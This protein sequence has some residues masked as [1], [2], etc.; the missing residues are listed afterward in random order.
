MRK[1][2]CCST[3]F[4]LLCV[5]GVW[6]FGQLRWKSLCVALFWYLAYADAKYVLK[7]GGHRAKFG[8]TGVEIYANE[9]ICSYHVLICNRCSAKSIT[10]T[11]C[12]CNVFDITGNIIIKKKKKKTSHW[13]KNFVTWYIEEIRHL[14]ELRSKYQ[15]QNYRKTNY[16]F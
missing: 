2:Q 10:V 3:Q 5:K 7:N 11:S 14:L 1:T 13:R 4:V 12:F 6:E 9:L 16:L 8:A 15:Y